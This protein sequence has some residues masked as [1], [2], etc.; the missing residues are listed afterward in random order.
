M[1]RFHNIHEGETCLIIGNGPS[2]NDIPVWFLESYPSFGCNYIYKLEDFKPTYYVAVDGH[3]QE[4]ADKINSL[5]T[6]V[7]KFLPTPNRDSWTGPNIFRFNHR[8]GALWPYSKVPLWPSDLLGAQG[9]T[10]KNVT[11]VSVQLAYFMGFETMLL[12]GMDNTMGE[13][14]SRVPWPH[15]YHTQPDPKM[16]GQPLECEEAFHILNQGMG[17]RM[18]N[19]STHTSITKI[20]RDDWRNWVREGQWENERNQDR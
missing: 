3:V 12:V 14:T 6:D 11:H 9:I 18:I 1:K 5:Y 10:Y 16:P 19:L 13:N 4:H 17:N 15:F 20:P 7:P 2:L 8:P